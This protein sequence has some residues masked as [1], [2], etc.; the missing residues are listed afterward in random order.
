M[1][2]NLPNDILPKSLDE[3]LLE[4]TD[5]STVHRDH[6]DPEVEIEFRKFLTKA[7]VQR[8]SYLAL[9]LVD[10]GVTSAR[11]LLPGDVEEFVRAELLLEMPGLFRLRT[12]VGSV[13]K[14]PLVK[15]A[16]RE[17][18]DLGVHT[19]LDAVRGKF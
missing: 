15:D 18:T 5:L 14:F 6:S 7:S 11:F 12:H 13:Q 1:K 3:S 10:Q 8:H 2:Q 16:T 9:V 19:V 17:E 4:H